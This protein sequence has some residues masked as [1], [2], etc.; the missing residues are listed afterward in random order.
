MALGASACRSEESG[1]PAGTGGLRGTGGGTTGT[2]EQ[3]P[4]PT[5]FVGVPYR[6]EF[7]SGGRS[8]GRESEDTSGA[9]D[10][11]RRFHLLAGPLPPGLTWRAPGVL[12]GT[13][14]TEG[15]ADLLVRDEA[16]GVEH[17]LRLRVSRKRWLAYRSDERA[18]GQHLLYLTNLASP[19]EPPFL[20]TR[21]AQIRAEVLSGHYR[22]A[23]QDEALAYLV[24]ATR[25]GVRELYAVDLSGAR[26]QPA[27]R[28]DHGAPVRS[29]A[30]SPDGRR[31]AYVSEEQGRLEAYV[32]GWPFDGAR[33]RVESAGGEGNVA[34]VHGGLLLVEAPGGGSHV[35]WNTPEGFARGERRTHG[36]RV[37]WAQGERA[38]LGEELYLCAGSYH[39]VDFAGPHAAFADAASV[40]PGGARGDASRRTPWPQVSDGV[41]VAGDVLRF[42]RSGQVVAAEPLASCDA[43][44]WG[45]DGQTLLSVEAA[46]RLRLSRVPHDVEAAALE[47]HLVPGDY[48]FVLPWPAPALSDS[49]EWL[50]FHAESGVFVSRLVDGRPSPALSATD[51]MGLSGA[52]IVDSTFGLAS[53]EPV[54]FV[55]AETR[56]VVQ[57]VGLHLGVTPPRP[58]I[59]FQQAAGQQRP[60]R[61]VGG[62]T[63]GSF[64]GF[65]VQERARGAQE[66][67]RLN[68]RVLHTHTPAEQGSWLLG[69]GLDCVPERDL[70]PPARVHAVRCESVAD[71]QF[72]P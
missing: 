5:A 61:L 12:E 70:G 47:H 17:L 71:A 67:A 4:L 28:L 33:L 21:D 50:K 48:G 63:D 31:L 45:A 66:A 49:G 8:Q 9:A 34:W 25:D 40:D 38:L 65:S 24:D 26:P 11:G 7:G 18:V 20:L 23:P 22:F 29:F 64:L 13:P 30:W 36:G 42:V 62:L 52:R 19:G 68:V 16:R 72:Q 6:Y 39:R 32:I 56:E 14:Q 57:V 44:A 35:L 55:L 10:V 59:S 15:E 51:A 46:G 43:L 54:L 1:E 2:G 58:R 53:T 37:L 27:E 3:Q 69:A 41:V 60:L